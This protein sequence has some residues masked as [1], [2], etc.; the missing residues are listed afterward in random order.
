MRE[1]LR[2][3]DAVLVIAG[4][5]ATA[6]GEAVIKL[7]AEDEHLRFDISNTEALRRKLVLSS[8]LLRLAR[9]LK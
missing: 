6:P 2:S 5:G 4:A 8:K 3:D 1:A 9:R 7:I